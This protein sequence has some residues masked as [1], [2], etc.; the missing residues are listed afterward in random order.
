VQEALHQATW[1]KDIA[2]DLS[3]DLIVEFF[4]LWALLQPMNISLDSSEEDS[5][6][7]NLESSGRYSAKLAYNIQFAGSIPSNFPRLIWRIWAPPKCKSFLWLLLQDRLWTASRLQV[8]GWEN[9]YFCGLCIRNLET[10]VH[11]FIECPIARKVWDLVA[12]WSNSINLKSSL[13]S[14]Q[15]EVEDWF[16]SMVQGGNKMAHTL[17]ILTTWCIWKQRNAAV[18]RNSICS[19]M[20]IFSTIKD[21]CSLWANAGGIA[22]RP[23]TIVSNLGSN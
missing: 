9:N 11:L 19:E 5:I 21:E 23:F 4:K 13:W 6:T 14:E 2:H 18:F 8:R 12:T 16:L 22:L 15:G 1:V 10:A 3:N 20:Q 7:W 17:A